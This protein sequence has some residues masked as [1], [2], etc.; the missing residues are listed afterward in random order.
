MTTEGIRIIEKDDG[1]IIMIIDCRRCGG[2]GRGGW[3]NTCDSC[4][5][6]GYKIIQ[7]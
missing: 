3:G 6:D 5:G 1:S 7:G 2:D 4:G